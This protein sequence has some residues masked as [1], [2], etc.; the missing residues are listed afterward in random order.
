M[1]TAAL[2]ILVGQIA[3]FW[4]LPERTLHEIGLA[5]AV[6]LTILGMAMHWHAPNH[7]MALEEL[8]KDGKV[9]PEEANRQIRFLSWCA[10]VVL[11]VGVM[12]LVGVLYDLVG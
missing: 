7:R 11:L 2:A 1:N 8:A 6:I 3:A 4:N 12:V 5:A 9:T 10:R